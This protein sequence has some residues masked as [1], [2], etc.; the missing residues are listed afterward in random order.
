MAK[1][2]IKKE[3][4]LYSSS[5]TTIPFY[6]PELS[7]D[8]NYNKGPFGG[9]AD[10]NIYK[11]KGEPKYNVLGQKIYYPIG[12]PAGPLVNGKFV[13]AALDKG[14]SIVTYKTVRSRKHKA[15]GWPN[16]LSVAI[17]GDLTEEIAENG[18]LGHHEFD[19]PPTI[20]N[21]F[22]VPSF[23]PDT[24][25]KDIADCVSYAGTGRLVVGSFQGTASEDHNWSKY[26]KDFILC[27]RLMKETGVKAM[28]ANLSCPNEGHANFLCY[29]IPRTREISEGIKNEIGNIPLVLKISYFHDIE[30]LRI[31]IKNIGK[32]V[33]GISSVNTLAAKIVDADGGQALPGEGRIKSGVCGRAIR[34]AGLD[35]TKK[36]KKLRDEKKMKFEIIGVG[37]VI[38]PQDFEAYIKAGADVVESATGAMWNPYLAQEIR[39]KYPN[40]PV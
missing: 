7:Y 33:D 21:S 2:N 3:Q 24:W 11:E 31:L 26:L 40:L 18:L 34:W 36:L 6:D 25:Q 17:K 23:D 15:H 39:A 8:E 20:T 10:G 1:K 13:K 14:F 5:K 4:K 38:H 9:F 32:V 28:E 16:V 19:D 35:M 37:G 30:H 27:A 12:I 29:D 22:G